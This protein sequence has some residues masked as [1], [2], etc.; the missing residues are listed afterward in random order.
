MLLSSFTS[1]SDAGRWTQ[2]S[3]SAVA[4]GDGYR[5][6]T[7]RN[8]ARR[9]RLRPPLAWSDGLARGERPDGARA[10]QWLDNRGRGPGRRRARRRGLADA[11]MAYARATRRGYVKRGWMSY[12]IALRTSSS[13]KSDSSLAAN[14]Q[15]Y[16]WRNQRSP[17][18]MRS[19]ARFS[20]RMR[21][22]SVAGTLT[23]CQPG[24]PS[25]QAR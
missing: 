18:A 3:E 14:S 13:G 7:H 16:S 11:A 24:P 8:W 5:H 10:R 1:V 23:R 17:M 12:L 9:R 6:E 20:G 2:I 19:R 25:I 4:G 15:R 22:H 21:G